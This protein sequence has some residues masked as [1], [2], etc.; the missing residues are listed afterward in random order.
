MKKKAKR[1]LLA[2]CLVLA[3]AAFWYL[4]M[5]LFLPMRDY[6]EAEELIQEKRYDEAASGFAA[7][8]RQYDLGTRLAKL[9]G[10]SDAAER[11]PQ[12]QYAKAEYLREKGSYEDA[13]TAFEELGDYQDS[14]NQVKNT[15]LLEADAW[16]GENSFDQAITL[17]E[18]LGDYDGGDFGSAG[19]LLDKAYY[20]RAVKLEVIG[21]LEDAE[22]GFER[23]EDY[24]DAYEKLREVRYN[25]ARNAL[26]V[27][28]FGTAK[29]LFTRVG[30]YKDA[31]DLL[32]ILD[33]AVDRVYR[34]PY[35][36]I[37]GKITNKVVSYLWIHSVIVPGKLDEGISV[38]MQE[39]LSVGDLNPSLFGSASY[40]YTLEQVRDAD[41]W[42]FTYYGS[43]TEDENGAVLLEAQFSGDY[44]DL[45]TKKVYQA[46][47]DEEEERDAQKA[48]E[49]AKV[50]EP[51][52]DA[53]EEALRQEEEGDEAEKDK[54]AEDEIG[55]KGSQQKE[56]EAAD[57]KDDHSS[58]GE[59]KLPEPEPDGMRK[60]TSVGDE[61]KLNVIKEGFRRRLRVQL[62]EKGNMAFYN[63]TDDERL[64][65]YC[66]V[67]NCLNKGEFVLSD[68]DSRR[69]YCSEHQKE[70]EEDPAYDSENEQK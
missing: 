37:T 54:D 28:N 44:K 67:S 6:R 47:R 58:V 46:S 32:A 50:A 61:E 45:T 52:N 55:N 48:E 1:I 59:T 39:D 31:K 34:S 41:T 25:M 8:S 60:W 13:V 11:V 63:D 3:A 30:D 27:Y 36:D 65:H 22:A 15:R 21:K 26:L 56:T 38:K 16:I 20:T 23:T 64:P 18:E 35:T 10:F 40:D 68:A 2:S 9:G 4:V 42:Y 53:S 14:E 5:F 29:E 49:V 62:A 24:Q 51:E 69:Y 19:E 17:L 7:L 70:Y 12:T 33:S 66:S 43:E 57:E